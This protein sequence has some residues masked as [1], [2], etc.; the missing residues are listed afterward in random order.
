M[1]QLSTYVDIFA[2]LLEEYDLLAFCKSICNPRKKEIV[3]CK[4]LR[5]YAIL[6]YIYFQPKKEILLLSTA[7][8]ICCHPL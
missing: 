3:Y 7:A 6:F 5:Y 2:K 1:I 8:E 4:T